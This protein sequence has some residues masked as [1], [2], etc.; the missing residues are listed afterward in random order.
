VAVDRQLSFGLAALAGK[1]TG[2]VY[3]WDISPEAWGQA[4]S[5][6]LGRNE[7]RGRT[8]VGN[9][10][11][12]EPPLSACADLLDDE[13]SVRK[14]PEERPVMK[15]PRA[16]SRCHAQGHGDWKSG[17]TWTRAHSSCSQNVEAS[18]SPL[19]VGARSNGPAG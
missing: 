5:Q 17:G 2:R 4:L 14:R 1:D 11:S 6:R 15:P 3:A 12:V 19:H 13:Q 7:S 9:V 16:D 10:A 8:I 18:I